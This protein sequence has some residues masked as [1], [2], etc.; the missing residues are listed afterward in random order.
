M[1]RAKRFAYP[2]NSSLNGWITTSA[3]TFAPHSLDSAVTTG[4]G[5]GHRKTDSLIRPDPRSSVGNRLVRELEPLLA[6]G[7]DQGWFKERL[8]LATTHPPS[9][10][11]FVLLSRLLRSEDRFRNHS[12]NAFG[13]VHGLCDMIVD[14]HARNHVGLLACEMRKSLRNEIDSFAHGDL[15]RIV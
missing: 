3:P 8:C 7:D 6:L 5:P 13:A 9:G 2:K 15:H 10:H 14:G 12:M 4:V 11:S 1:R